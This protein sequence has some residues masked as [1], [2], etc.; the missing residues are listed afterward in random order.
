MEYSK[1]EISIEVKVISCLGR[2][3]H[4]S[5]ELSVAGRVRVQV[6]TLNVNRRRY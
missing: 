4:M 1:L 6:R 5:N 3:S 2:R